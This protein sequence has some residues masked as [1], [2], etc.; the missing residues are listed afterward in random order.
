MYISAKSKY[1]FVDTTLKR[2]SADTTL[3]HFPVDTNLDYFSAAM[4]LK[5][6]TVD[7]V[8]KQRRHADK[9]PTCGQDP[10]SA[11]PAHF[12]TM[13]RHHQWEQ[14]TRENQTLHGLEPELLF[15]KSK[16][17]FINQNRNIVGILS[18]HVYY[19]LG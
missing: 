1:V 10:A 6:S 8:Q 18:P 15:P 16:K 19:F 11:S 4:T 12:K 14:A 2:F 13:S 7:T 17:R 9:T 5:H 3:N